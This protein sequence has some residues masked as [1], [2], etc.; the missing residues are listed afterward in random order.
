MIIET[1]SRLLA[2][3]GMTVRQCSRAGLLEVDG[4]D[5]AEGCVEGGGEEEGGAD[6]GEGVVGGVGG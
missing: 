6:V 5:A 4:E 3:S 2:V 1:D